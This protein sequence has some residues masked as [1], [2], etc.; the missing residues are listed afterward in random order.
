MIDLDLSL[1]IRDPLYRLAVWIIIAQ[2]V[3]ILVAALIA[4]VIRW[5][6]PKFDEIRNKEI[7]LA[8]QSILNL[9]GKEHSH[10]VEEVVD[11]GVETNQKEQESKEEKEAQKL[12]NEASI[13][14]VIFAFEQVVTR[15]G[16]VEQRQLRASTIALWIEKHALRLSKSWWWWR[17]FEGVLL[18]RSVGTE[19]SEESLVELLR[20]PHPTVSF[21]AAWALARVSPIRGLNELVHYIEIEGNYRAQ[22]KMQL[23]LSFSQQVTLLKEL[24]LQH[25]KPDALETLFDQL[26]PTLKPVLIEALIQSG[27]GQA[28]PMIRRG[29]NSTDMEVRVA[30][31]K[32]AATSRLSLSEA[33]LVKGLTDPFWPVRAQASKAVGVLRAINLVP[34]LCKCLADTQWWVRN[35][36]ARSLVQLGE[37]GIEALNYISQFGEDRFARDISRLVLNEAIMSQNRSVMNA[38]NSQPLKTLAKQA[39]LGE[40]T[41]LKQ[42]R[43]SALLTKEITALGI[44]YRR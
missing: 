3:F 33:E 34:D 23:K 40:A 43:S 13:R 14:S 16:E 39:T 2:I 20:D 29:I 12:L 27:R 35:N 1:Y 41:V 19:S 10:F 32:A 37:A 9:L 25:L 8:R 7:A 5:F 6:K 36:S 42:E 30:S 28:V 17:R 24:K 44:D 26:S 11:E 38:L 4:G 31:Y 18:L 22:A 21:Y 15:L